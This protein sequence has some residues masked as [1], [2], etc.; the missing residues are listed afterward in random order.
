MSVFLIAIGLYSARSLYFAVMEE[1]RIPIVYT[2]TAVG[3]ISVIGYTPDIFAGPAYG[4][5]LDSNPG[6]SGFQNVFWML[7]AFA[8][9]GAIATIIYYQKYGRIS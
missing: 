2:G 6:E 8:I 9:I 1:G 3:L 4:Y 5:L 7:T